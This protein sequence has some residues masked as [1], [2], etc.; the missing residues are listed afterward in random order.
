MATGFHNTGQTPPAD[1]EIPTGAFLPSS[2]NDAIPSDFRV[3]HS[4][5][6]VQAAF[7][8][9]RAKMNFAKGT[10]DT[11]DSRGN[12]GV[13]NIVNDTRKN[14]SRGADATGEK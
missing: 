2:G 4:R 5:E 9:V 6:E 12:P 10:A 8:E 11:I 3:F 14:A 13:A 7:A 1:Y